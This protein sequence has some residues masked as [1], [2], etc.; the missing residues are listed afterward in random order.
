MSTVPARTILEQ[1]DRKSRWLQV[2]YLDLETGAPQVGWVYKRHLL[3]LGVG[4]A[5][6][7]CAERPAEF[8]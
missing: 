7:S 2:V 3:E 6:S 8:S 4:D 5:T 1:I